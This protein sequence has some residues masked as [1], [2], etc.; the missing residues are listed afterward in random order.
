MRTNLV[1]SCGSAVTHIDPRC[2]RHAGIWFP[3]ESKIYQLG[4]LA[5]ELDEWGELGHF[6]V[7]VLGLLVGIFRMPVHTLRALLIRRAVH[8]F[9]Q[10]AA[11]SSAAASRVDE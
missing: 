10:G 2:T 4:P 3:Q 9:D 5:P 8:G 11:E 1:L 6:A 7:Q